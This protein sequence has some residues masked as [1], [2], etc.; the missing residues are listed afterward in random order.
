MRALTKG[1]DANKDSFQGQG[2]KTERAR[3]SRRSKTW[4]SKTRT[5][6]RN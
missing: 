4:P 5:R 2:P 1:K 3:T 6:T